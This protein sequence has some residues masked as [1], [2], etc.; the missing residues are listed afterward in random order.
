MPNSALCMLV[1]VD[2]Q[3]VPV[4]PIFVIRLPAHVTIPRIPGD[5]IRSTRISWRRTV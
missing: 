1:I 4:I 5:R 2:I 3:G